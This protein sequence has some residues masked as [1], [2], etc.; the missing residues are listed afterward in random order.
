MA[1]EKCSRLQKVLG[2]S[3]KGRKKCCI[4]LFTPFFECLGTFYRFPE[5]HRFIIFLLFLPFPKRSVFLLS[6]LSVTTCVLT[7]ALKP[8]TFPLFREIVNQIL[9]VGFGGVVGEPSGTRNKRQD[10]VVNTIAK[11]E[12]VSID[13]DVVNTAGIIV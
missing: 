3:Q 4:Y 5:R 9:D 12:F 6:L 10:A 2:H 8:I 11:S 1:Y 13:V 7:W